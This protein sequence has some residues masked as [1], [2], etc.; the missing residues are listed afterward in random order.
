MDSTQSLSGNSLM[1]NVF[2]FSLSSTFGGNPPAGLQDLPA[3][4]QD[5][6]FVKEQMTN[7]LAGVK[8][9]PNSTQYQY[10]GWKLGLMYRIVF[11]GSLVVVVYGLFCLREIGSTAIFDLEHILEMTAASTGLHE[12][13]VILQF[14]STLITGMFFF[15]SG[16]GHQRVAFEVD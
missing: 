8:V 15:E 13:A 16:G 11:D 9:T 3:G 10:I 2:Y 6:G 12:S 5:A 4:K 7:K 14:G 1:W